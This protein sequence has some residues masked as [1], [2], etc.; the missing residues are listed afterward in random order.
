MHKLVLYML[1]Y[2]TCTNCTCNVN[3]LFDT[4][5]FPSKYIFGAVWPHDTLY[6]LN[7]TFTLL[8]QLTIASCTYIT[9]QLMKVNVNT[10]KLCQFLIH[11]W[12]CMRIA[13][14]GITGT[15]KWLLHSACYGG[16][17]A[18]VPLCDAICKQVQRL[19]LIHLASVFSYRGQLV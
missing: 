10:S 1:V 15:G 7:L 19:R 13:H 5:C 8:F 18:P 16:H 14:F 11:M 4:T 2:V 17:N 3:V 9:S 6:P 12:S